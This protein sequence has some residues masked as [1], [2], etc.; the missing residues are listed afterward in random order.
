MSENASVPFMEHPFHQIR[1]RPISDKVKSRLRNGHSVRIKPMEDM[2]GEGLNL[3]VHSHRLNNMTKCMKSGKG[4]QVALAPAEIEANKSITGS[5]IFGKKA[6]NFLKKHGVKKLAYAVGSAVKPFAQKAISSLGAIGDTYAPGLGTLASQTA[7]D[8]LDRPE[9]YQKMVRDE[10]KGTHGMPTGN[11]KE[12]AIDMLA[13]RLKS[14]EFGGDTVGHLDR[15]GASKAMA[16]RASAE[17]AKRIGEARASPAGMGLYAGRGLGL[18]L[19]CGLY[20]GAMPRR[21]EYHSIGGRHQLMGQGVPA[22]MSQPFGVNYNFRTQ[23]PPSYQ[24][25]HA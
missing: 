15:A 14:G 4:T 5:G 12:K 2:E 21:R 10:M 17:I 9:A 7:N 6:D 19:G 13:D 24:Q 22:L 20:G 18:G 25:L 3:I 16:D 11:F 8:Y 23:M 1:I